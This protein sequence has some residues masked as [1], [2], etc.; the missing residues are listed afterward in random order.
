M[1]K[2]LH[3]WRLP[4]SRWIGRPFVAGNP[5]QPQRSLIVMSSGDSAQSA[6]EVRMWLWQRLQSIEQLAQKRMQLLMCQV[7]FTFEFF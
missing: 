7:S 6:Q 1:P 3:G 4:T 2:G 5:H